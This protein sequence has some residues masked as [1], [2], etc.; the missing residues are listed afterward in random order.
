MRS[1]GVAGC[2]AEVLLAIL[3]VWGSALRR[4]INSMVIFYR[5]AV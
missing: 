5:N 3:A 2:N 1:V 4:E